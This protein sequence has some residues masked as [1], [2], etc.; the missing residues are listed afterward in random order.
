MKVE[1]SHGG[2]YTCTPT[3]EIGSEG[4]SEPIHVVVQ[5]PPVFT[6]TP[7]NIYLRKPG[8]S[9]HMVCDALDGETRPT[10]V[11]FKVSKNIFEK[12][13]KSISCLLITYS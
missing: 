3:N 7:H 4:A 13:K 6:L 8:D 10:I 12:K 5:H 2:E 9:I 11:W 1:E